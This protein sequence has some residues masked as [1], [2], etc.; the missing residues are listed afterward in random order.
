M[1]TECGAEWMDGI[2][3]GEGFGQGNQRMD[4]YKI[5]EPQDVAGVNEY[6]QG[7]VDDDGV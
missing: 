6:T 5:S 1:V 7:G 4:T 3:R 2:L